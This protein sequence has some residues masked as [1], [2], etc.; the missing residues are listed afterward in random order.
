MVLE[1]ISDI[2]S[3][4]SEGITDVA[5]DIGEFSKNTV[6]NIGDQGM[7]ALENGDIQAAIECSDILE[8][9]KG[10]VSEIVDQIGLNKG[11]IIGGLKVAGGTLGT[12]A[13]L[14]TPGFQAAGLA[15]AASTIS[16]LKDLLSQSGSK[17][18]DVLA[19]A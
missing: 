12:V 7:E 3:D 18:A 8:E 10:M 13:A 11:M 9:H 6:E 1:A 5:I 4:I 16:G 15:A 2:V 17:K 14:A 19:N